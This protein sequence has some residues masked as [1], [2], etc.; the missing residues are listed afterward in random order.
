MSFGLLVLCLLTCVAA[1]IWSIES[2]AAV[3]AAEIT[4][5]L[6]IAVKGTG[7]QAGQVDTSKAV[8]NTAAPYKLLKSTMFGSAVT[9]QSAA[10]C[11]GS[12]PSGS[13]L[14][15]SHAVAPKPENTT[16]TV[17]VFGCA[18]TIVPV[19]FG[20]CPNG[21]RIDQVIVV[22]APVFQQ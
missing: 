10:P 6:S 14:L 4:A 18:R 13:V 17:R 3:T 22:H 2:S 9:T 15:C 8:A 7:T 12:P 21:I 5:R 20:G 19:P 1:A 11:V 16:V